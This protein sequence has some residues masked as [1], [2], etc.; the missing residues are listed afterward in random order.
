[1]LALNIE[2]LPQT[3]CQPKARSKARK[4]VS[5]IAKIPF[6]FIFDFTYSGW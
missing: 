5:E 2:R 1:M 6:K 3:R 4:Q